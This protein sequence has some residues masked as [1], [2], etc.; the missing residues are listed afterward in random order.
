MQVKAG[1]IGSVLQLAGHL[2]SQPREE[3]HVYGYRML[4][5]I[6]QTRWDT[7]HEQQKDD[8][9]VFASR[10]LTKGTMWE[11]STRIWA[12]CLG[13]HLSLWVRRLNCRFSRNL[14][15]RAAALMLVGFELG[16]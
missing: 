8:L 5:D 13:L 15:I 16:Y 2:C 14:S 12:I 7:C 4:S 11:D 10:S 9:L 1:N 6:V 3:L